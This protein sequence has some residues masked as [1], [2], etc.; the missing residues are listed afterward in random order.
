[1]GQESSACPLFPSLAGM[2]EQPINQH[3]K[4]EEQ[5]PAQ[6]QIDDEDRIG[7]HMPS[8][9]RDQLNPQP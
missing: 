3:P 1:M 9:G 6:K 4:P 2:A 7:S 5:R 8:A